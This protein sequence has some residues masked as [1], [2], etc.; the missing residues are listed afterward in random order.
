MLYFDHNA[1]TPL[2]ERVL[3]A[4]APYLGAFYGNPSSLYRMGRICRG[5]IDTAREQVA[6]LVGAHPSEVVFTSG[7]TEA[8]NLALKGL[9][10]AREPG[11]IVAGATEHPSVSEPLEFLKARGWRIATIPVGRDGL[12]DVAFIESLPAGEIRFATLMLANN[13]TGVIQ[14][15]APIAGW[16]RELGI[17]FHCDAVQAAGKIAI[18]FK[19]SGVHMMSLSGHKIYGPK[20]VGALILDKAVMLE[21]LLHGG[22]QEQGLRGGTENVAAIVGFGKA[23]ELALSELEERRAR[24]LGLRERLEAGLKTIPGAVVFA[25]GSER[26]PNTVQFGIAGYDGEALVMNL[27]RQGIAVS[28]GSACASGAGEPSPVLVAMGVEPEVAKSAV[29]V[30]FGKSNTE[31]EVDRFLDVLKKLV[32]IST[33]ESRGVMPI[34]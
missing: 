6:A 27:D 30:S 25:E 32:G 17:V 8:N 20:G 12:A 23:A 26:L 14:D 10:F 29:R 16:F 1:T 4:M 31:T 18:D 2:D 22:G 24:L 7:G 3:E 34:I 9:A 33:S 21:P 19:A 15:I 5:A 13:E 28:S 11:L